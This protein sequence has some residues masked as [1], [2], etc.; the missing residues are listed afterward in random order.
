MHGF[1]VFHGIFIWHWLKEILEHG[2][3]SPWYF[4]MVL[5]TSQSIKEAK[6]NGK[7]MLMDLFVM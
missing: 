4:P 7:G 3:I 6:E 1:G 2:F 5:D